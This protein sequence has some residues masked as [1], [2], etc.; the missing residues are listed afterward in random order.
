MR[1]CSTAWI[2]SGIVRPNLA[3]ATRGPQRPIPWVL[4]LARTP[5]IGLIPKQRLPQSPVELLQFALER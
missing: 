1:N 5:K 2:I 3:I 4:N